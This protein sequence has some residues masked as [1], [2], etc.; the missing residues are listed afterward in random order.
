LKFMDVRGAEQYTA[1]NVFSYM[2][3]ILSKASL[4]WNFFKESQEANQYDGKLYYDI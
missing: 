3:K 2:W 4:M 1:K